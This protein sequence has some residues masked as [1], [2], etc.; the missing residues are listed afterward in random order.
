MCLWCPWI[1]ACNLEPNIWFTAA[2]WSTIEKVFIDKT[3]W[4][5]ME[6]VSQTPDYLSVFLCSF[7]SCL[8]WYSE[9]KFRNV[10][11]WTNSQALCLEHSEYLELWLHIKFLSALKDK[12][13]LF[14]T[15]KCIHVFHSKLLLILNEQMDRIPPHNWLYI[16]LWRV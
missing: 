3:E 5:I 12:I 6:N 15:K 7:N 11:S 8:D 1:M 9:G 4:N 13:A 14:C 16:W 10:K 2:I